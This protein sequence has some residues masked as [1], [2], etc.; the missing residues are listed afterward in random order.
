MS[1]A[2]TIAAATGCARCWT[3]FGHRNAINLCLDM[4]KCWWQ[5]NIIADDFDFYKYFRK[6][7][8]NFGIKRE[9]YKIDLSK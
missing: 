8:P 1:K 5:T 4:L 9:I 2:C 7:T 3:I 6:K